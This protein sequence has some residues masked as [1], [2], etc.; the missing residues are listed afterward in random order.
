[1]KKLFYSFFALALTALTFTSCEDVPAPYL[2]P[3]DNNGEEPTT[4][5]DEN[6]TYAS[7]F[8]LNTAL[9][10]A[11]ATGVYVKGYIVG[12]VYGQKIADGSVFDAD[13]CTV[14]TNVLIAASPDEKDYKKCMPVQLPRGD[15]RTKLNLKDNKTVLKQEVLLYGDIATYFGVNG[16]KNV[17][18]AEIN[19]QAVGTKPGESTGGTAYKKVNSIAD[20]T[21]I[22][23]ALK[24]GSTYVVAKPVE[25]G[26]AYGW[27]YTVDVAMADEAIAAEAANEFTFKA[28][29]GGYTIQDA[30]G[31]YYY[32]SG[33]YNSFQVS[34]SLPEADYVWTVTFNAEG[35]VVITNVGK[36]KTIQYSSEFSSY[37]AYTEVTNKLPFL[38]KK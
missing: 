9:T 36:N 4:P 35:N 22:L 3:N 29:E 2:N 28:V 25:S 23:A 16:I 5:T 14:N 17:T 13:T 1:M 38:F 11:A 31:R 20:G 21:Y 15:V 24:E 8:T 26:K 34:E 32:M 18:Y 6:G 19:G 27:L 12:Y 37:G 33:N 7:P 30:T 10:H